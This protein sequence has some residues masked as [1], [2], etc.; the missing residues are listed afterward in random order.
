MNILEIRSIT[1]EL[2]RD[3]KPSIEEFEK[4]LPYCKEL[5]NS[6]LETNDL[7]DVHQYAN[8]LKQLGNLDE[9]ES[10]CDNIYQQFAE[11]ELSK[12]QER[13]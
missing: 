2:L 8:C 3:K 9:A 1:R 12:G 11:R 4:A 13:P 7:W 10:I 5:Y 6:F